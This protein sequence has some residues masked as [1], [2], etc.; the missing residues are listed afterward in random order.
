MYDFNLH[1]T[2]KKRSKKKEQ[3]FLDESLGFGMTP[4]KKQKIPDA[5]DLDKLMGAGSGPTTKEAKYER[6]PVTAE[7]KK[8]VLFRQRDKCAW[9]NCKIHFHR[10][11]YP[12]QFDHI[13][14]VDKGGISSISNIQ[15]LCPNHH[16]VKTHHENVK[17]AEKPRQK[18]KKKEGNSMF[19]SG[20]F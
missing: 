16:H 14:R 2:S 6:V 17:K 19:K 7:Q 12:P 20:L 15:A 18:P 13:K 1:E 4:P 11:G 5:F 9:H 10:D 8:A 3:N